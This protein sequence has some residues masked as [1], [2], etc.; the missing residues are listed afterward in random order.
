MIPRP[1]AL[2]AQRS[3]RLHIERVVLDGLLVERSQGPSFQAALESELTRLF[4]EQGIPP[5]LPQGA[6]RASL[7]GGAIRTAHGF[8]T[9]TM[10][11]QIARAV[12][13]GLSQ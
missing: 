6:A 1:S 8:K 2:A 12:Y 9:R 11:A 3:V 13:G 4:A 10:A 7:D 5:T